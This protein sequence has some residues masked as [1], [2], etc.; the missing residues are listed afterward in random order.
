MNSQSNAQI[1]VS[2]INSEE[3]FRELAEVWNGLVTRVNGTVFFRHEWFEAAWAWRKE[4]SKLF[5]LVARTKNK[6]VGILPLIQTLKR[7]RFLNL[8]GLEFLTVP[9]T[10]ICDL[11]VDQENRKSI[12]EAFCDALHQSSFAWDQLHL[13][14][15][16]ET[17]IALQAFKSGMEKRRHVCVTNAQGPNLFVKLA[18]SWE[19]YYITRSRSLKKA[20]NLAGNRLKKTGTIEIQWFSS[21]GSGEASIQTA[22]DESIDISRRSWKQSTGNSLDHSGPMQFIKTLTTHAARNGWLSLWLLS[23]DGKA[24]AM[25]YQLLEGGNVYALRADFDASCEETSPGSHLMRT[26][27]ETLFARGL[28]KYYMG[29]GENAYK[30]RWT[31]ESDTLYQ[32]VVHGTTWRGRLAHLLDDSLKPAARAIRDKLT[33]NDK[34]VNSKN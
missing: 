2:V 29:P 31:D 30:T 13:R 14:Y 4:D 18:G 17:S 24:L 19:D 23:V 25:E 20:N 1:D 33:R 9:D 28:H 3:A 34:P 16:C 10:Q 7:D 8:R 5:I 26:L 21:P 6:I 15:L 27:L 22:L 32:L 11:I 12:V